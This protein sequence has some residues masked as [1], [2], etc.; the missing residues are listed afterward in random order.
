MATIPTDAHDLFDHLL[1]AAL[2][3]SPQKAREIDTTL[4]FK[5][6]GSGDWTID[7]SRAVAAPTC[8]PG[9]AA[10]ARCTVEMASSD[11]LAMLSDPNVGM[12]LYYQKKLRIS[13]DPTHALK[14]AALFDLLRAAP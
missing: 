4:C 2:T 10:G 5:I 13:G 12:Q 6:E 3:H 8:L 9:S 1:P 7:C 11:F 14:I